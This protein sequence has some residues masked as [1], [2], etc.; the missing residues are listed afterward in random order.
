MKYNNLD[1]SITPPAGFAELVRRVEALR[2]REGRAFV[3]IDGRCGSGKSTLAALLAARFDC[4]LIH[5][6]DFFLR[7]EQRTPA[8]L[9]QPGGNFDRERFYAE[10]LAPLL[11]GRD[12]LYRPYD[13]HAGALQPP[14]AAP[15]RPVVLAEGSYSCHPDLW[16]CYGLH[17]FVTAPLEVR[18]E[19]LSRRPGADLE[20]F[21]TRWIPLEEAYFAASQLETRC[22]VILHNEA[23]CK[24]KTL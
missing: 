10:V 5:A 18:L 21:R 23:S 20:A 15:L 6:D 17:V 2:C 8:R 1:T 13:C 12:A 14:V 11:A 24:L 19:R 22:E 16:D 9:A 4:T 3:A 7:P